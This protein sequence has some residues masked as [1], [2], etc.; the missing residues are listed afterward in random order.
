M[1]QRLAIFFD[2]LVKFAGTKTARRLVLGVFVA[3]ALLLSF[4]THIGVP[5]DEN[6]HLNFIR[7]YADHS[8][9]PVFDKQTP[10]WSL[11]DKT[12]EVDYLYHYGTSFVARVLPGETTEVYV[13]RIISV[14]TALLTMIV[15]ARLFRRLD[16]PAAAITVALATITNLPMVL[17]L[18]AA[19]NNDVFV[20]LGFVLSLLLVLRLWKRPSLLDTLLLLNVI[21]AGG[22]IKRTLLPLGFIMALTAAVLIYKKWT[23][24]VK[25]VKKS[26]WRVMLAAASLVIV[27][28]LFVERIGGNL[29]Y[30]GAIAPTCEQVQGDKACEVFWANSRKKWLDAGA[31]AGTMSWLGSGVTRD[32]SPMPLPVFAV[33]WL[34]Y[35]AANITDIQ[36]QGWRHKATPPTWL[37]PSL[38]LLVI[39]AIGYGVLRD[40][41]QWRKTKENMALLRLLAVGMAIFVVVVHLLVNHSEYLT[42]QVFGLALNGRYILP[43]LLVLIGL[44]CYYVGRWLPH[45]VNQAIAVAVILAVVLF[46]GLWMMLRNSQLITG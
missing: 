29:Y 11:G 40:M 26:D 41:H 46:S 15:L 7:Y 25:S 37:A 14:L 17:M 35:S 42:Y 32:E 27:S 39:G 45:R 24:F 33:N 16:V 9:S 22:L 30:Y 2:K 43:A 12:R 36:T 8:L 31:P 3:Q 18:S 4:V 23:L 13:I 21:I 6:N 44:S 10:T 34:L 20:W 38:L 19:V 5:P 28:G 1:R